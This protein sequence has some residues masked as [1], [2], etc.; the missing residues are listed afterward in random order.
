MTTFVWITTYRT[1]KG[2]AF[3]RQVLCVCAWLHG[4]CVVSDP[5]WGQQAAAEVLMPVLSESTH[6]NT[7]YFSGEAIFSSSLKHTVFK[8]KDYERF[9]ATTFPIENTQNTV[10]C[11]QWCMLN[12]Q[13]ALKQRMDVLKWDNWGLCRKSIK[14]YSK[15]RNLKDLI[16]LMIFCS[17][18]SYR[19]RRSK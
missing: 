13:N 1:S 14:M 5:V 2:T 7:E 18:W 12:W 17:F 10:R 11:E 15:W 4:T 16:L 8:H 3:Y 9:T 19:R 6:S